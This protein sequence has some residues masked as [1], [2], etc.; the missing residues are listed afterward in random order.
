M[1]L[2]RTFAVV[3]IVGAAL[4]AVATGATR[5]PGSNAPKTLTGTWKTTLTSADLHRLK[6]PDAARS[7]TLAV[8]N[9]KYLSY[10]RALGFGPSNSGRDTVPFGVSGHRIYLSC[11]NANGDII[12]GYATYAWSIANGALRFTRVAEPCRDPILRD[13]I[14]ILTSHPWRKR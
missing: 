13:R 3:A 1:R 5:I 8:V 11:L 9:A 14:L 12:A 2:V 7:W 4:A 6:A 10:S